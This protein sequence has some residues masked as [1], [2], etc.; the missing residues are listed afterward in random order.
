MLLDAGCGE[1]S[2][3]S[4]MLKRLEQ[5]EL[6]G[7]TL[8]G[9]GVDL[10]KEGVLL[11]ARSFPEQ[12]WCVADLA[13]SPFADHSFHFITN[14]L[15]P[16]NY[17]EFKRLLRKDGELI[18]IVPNSDYLMELRGALNGDRMK[19]DDPRNKAIDLFSRQ[20]KDVA[21]ERIRYKMIIDSE[22]IGSL[23]RMTPLAWNAGEQG[24]LQIQ[25]SAG[26]EVTVDLTILS[27]KP[28]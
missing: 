23:A 16:S 26:T 21:T 4:G 2:H 10:A 7:S 6:R 3:L 13:C 15:S 11:A 1:G 20:M 25:E 12:T 27:G 22:H 17:S 19:Q 24:I 18:K 8:H 28:K 14:I 9:V 5:L